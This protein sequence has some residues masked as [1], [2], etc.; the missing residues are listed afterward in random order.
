[1]KAKFYYSS[2]QVSAILQ[3]SF[4]EGKKLELSVIQ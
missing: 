4:F 3:F 2:T 1:M